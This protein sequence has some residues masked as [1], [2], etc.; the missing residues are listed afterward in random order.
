MLLQT[1]DF[2]RAFVS[3]PYLFG[4]I[5]ANHALGDIYA[6]GGRPLTALAIAT[7]PPAAEPILEDELYQMLCGG[8]SVLEAAGARLVGGHSAEGGE[9]ALGFAVTGTAEAERLLRKGGLR[10][11]D[12]L[13]L[14]KPIGTGT[15]LAAEMRGA[16][17]ARWVDGAIAAMLQPAAAAAEVLLAHGATAATD[18]TGFGVL[19]HLVEMLRASGVAAAL[20]VDA[21]P[22]LDG[23]RECVASGI[24]S[25][26]H[27]SNAAF[28]RF[29]AD[30]AAARGSANYALLFD[31]QT[32]GGLLAGVPEARAASCVAAL[33][34]AGYAEAAGIGR[35]LDRGEPRVHLAEAMDIAMPVPVP[36]AT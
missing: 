26:L 22:V 27:P 10:P 28:A 15:L 13:V 2:F 30:D 7:L 25:T 32:A 34:E 36:V 21:F 18:V 11:G 14:T 17:K 33:R 8:R 3:D 35:V 19:G 4:R 29:L 12:R 16:A 1:V 6:M 24:T 31:P 9:L 5:A 20:D 23:A